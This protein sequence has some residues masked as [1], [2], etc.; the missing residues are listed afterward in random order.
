MSVTAA[1]VNHRQPIS[2]QRL[3]AGVLA[4]SVALNLC[5]VAGA[6]WSRYSKPETMTAS[7]HF[8]RLET[9]LNLNDQQRKAFE[10]YAAATRARTAQLRR[11]LQPMLDAAWI[12]IAKPQPDEAAILQGLTDASTR[13]RASQRE[14]VEATIALLATLDPDQRAKFV[15]DEQARRDALRRRRA[16]ETR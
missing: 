8:R 15:A 12:E 7:E 14:T 16:D 5:V 4:V 9:A 13:W 6:L 3:L 1:G 2:R 10:A 11:D